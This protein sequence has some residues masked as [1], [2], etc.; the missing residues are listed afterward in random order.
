MSAFEKRF[1][2]TFNDLLIAANLNE[3]APLKIDTKL[4]QN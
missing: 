3:F 2:L 1:A 4:L